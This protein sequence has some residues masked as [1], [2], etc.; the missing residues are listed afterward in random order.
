MPIE[1][2]IVM[3]LHISR[4]N[5]WRAVGLILIALI[6]GVVGVFKA[7]K[8]LNVRGAVRI[9]TSPDGLYRCVI[10]QSPLEK[11][12]GAAEMNVRVEDAT[13]QILINGDFGERY[14]ADIE[15]AGD[16]LTMWNASNPFG[17]LCHHRKFYGWQIELDADLEEI[18]DD[19]GPTNLRVSGPQI[20][21]AGLAALQHLTPLRSL[22]L[23]R[24]GV[25]IG[26][27]RRLHH[28]LPNL[29]IFDGLP[30]TQPVSFPD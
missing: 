15:W 22:I 19:Q 6:L 26:G 13:G 9:S 2:G 17:G 16:Y 1:P 14:V 5:Q 27:L 8:A 25:S 7:E 30:A 20:T 12:T 3:S 29:E 28:A 18:A 10:Y 24:T 4:R 23:D 21:D 11:W